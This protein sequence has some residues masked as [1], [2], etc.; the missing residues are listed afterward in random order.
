M[1]V[2]VPND[3]PPG[4]NLIASLT[5]QDFDAVVAVLDVPNSGRENLAAKNVSDETLR[6]AAETASSLEVGRDT[7]GI[8]REIFI[9]EVLD[10]LVSSK[11]LSL[12][13]LTREQLSVRLIRLLSIS[14]IQFGAKATSLWLENERFLISSRIISDVRPIFGD[15]IDEDTV[16]AALIVH[17]LRFEYSEAGER[18]SFF[19]FLDD[20]DIESLRAACERALVKRKAISRFLTSAKLA[21]VN[22]FAE[23]TGK[24]AMTEG[25]S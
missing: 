9:A 6:I 23:K 19:T 5:D 2:S 18:K 4:L 25:L 17:T 24:E 1:P 15:T 13:D 8:D 3:V 10:S 16:S 11:Q 7:L 22:P 14:S 21:V 20:D 12:K